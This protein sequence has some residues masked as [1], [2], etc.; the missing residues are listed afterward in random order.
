MDFLPTYR[1]GRRIHS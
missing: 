1:M